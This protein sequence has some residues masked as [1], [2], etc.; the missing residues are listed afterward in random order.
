MKRACMVAYTFYGGDNRVRRYAET[1]AQQG[2][3]VDAIVL[4]TPGM[5][6]MYDLKGVRVLGIQ[7]RIKNEKHSLT[8]LFRLG[9]F[10]VKSAVVLTIEHIKKPYSVVHV[11]SIPDFEVFSAIVPKLLGAKIILDI[12]DIVPELFMKKFNGTKKSPVFKMLLLVERFS[13]MFANH[14]IIA[15]DIWL[16]RISD[17]SIPPSKCSVVMNYPVSDIFGNVKRTR[18]PDGKY[19]LMY[20]GT[21]SHHQGIGTA[22]AAV[23]A[24]REEIPEIEFHIYGAGT[25]ENSLHEQVTQLQLEQHVKFFGVLPLEQIA[26]VMA[27]ADVGVEPKLANSFSDE[28]FSTKILEFMTLGVPVIASDTS[29]HKYYIT[30]DVVEYFHAG[31]VEELV[32]AIRKLYNEP[33]FRV[34]LVERASEY[35]KDFSW[36]KRKGAYLELAGALH[37]EKVNN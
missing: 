8:Y 35:I 27:N 31:S 37:V 2:W 14:V 10:L 21:L 7:K 36:D 25:D 24:L 30:D 5:P 19:L 16:K 11:H 33:E 28:A 22:I 20:P 6:K 34:K 23:N 29:V 9:W 15:N 26:E 3:S 4:E 13:G 32:V 17:R 1:L 12:H 18:E